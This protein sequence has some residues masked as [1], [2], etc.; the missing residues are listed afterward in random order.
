MLYNCDILV[1]DMGYSTKKIKSFKDTQ[2]KINKLILDDAKDLFNECFDIDDITQDLEYIMPLAEEIEDLRTKGQKH[3]NQNKT[4]VRALV[5]ELLLTLCLGFL[6][7]PAIFR[8]EKFYAIVV[9]VINTLAM[10]LY[11][12]FG[13]WYLLLISGLLYLI[14]VSGSISRIIIF[15]RGKNYFK[16]IKSDFNRDEKFYFT[17]L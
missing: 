3:K 7:I 16:K 11:F 12:Q 13:F 1:I 10:F 4:I 17:E 14:E 2:E 5:L 9:L 6:A 8:K 15:L